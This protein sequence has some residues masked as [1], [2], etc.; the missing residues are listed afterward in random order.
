MFGFIPYRPT[1]P[2]EP[3]L[4]PATPEEI[5]QTLSFALQFEGR[6]RVHQA[7]G[8]M[9]QITAERLVRH[10]ERSG[11]VLMKKP[12]A[13]APTVADHMRRPAAD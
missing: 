10:L 11:F 12:A 1:M 7:D 5:A 6:K 13:P 9:A 2:D 8:L 4:R 3:H